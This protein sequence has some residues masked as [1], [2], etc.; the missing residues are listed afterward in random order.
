M[1]AMPTS[2]VHVLTP[3]RF[4]ELPC[5][6]TQALCREATTDHLIR[7]VERGRLRDTKFLRP[8]P[9]DVTAQEWTKNIATLYGAIPPPSIYIHPS[10]ESP[11][12]PPTYRRLRDITTAAWLSPSD[13]LTVVH[14]V[15]QER[16]KSG[17]GVPDQRSVHF[18][19]RE[20][21][22]RHVC[23]V[24]IPGFEDKIKEYGRSKFEALVSGCF[25]A[26]QLLQT[27]GLLE[28]THFPAVYPFVP[29]PQTI[30]P[31]QSKKAKPN[32]V[33]A[34]P[35]RT[36][37]FWSLSTK[38]LGDLWY[39][40]IV[41]IDGSEGEFG[42][43]AILTLHPLP[44]IPDFPLSF[45]GNPVNVQLRK[46][47]SR[48]FS[49]DELE[50]LRRATLRI[51]RFIGNKPLVCNLNQLPYLLFPLEPR[52]TLLGSLH[53]PSW[54]HEEYPRLGSPC[55]SGAVMSMA[56]SAFLP[57][58]TES[59]ENV[60]KDLADAVIQDRKIEYTKHYFV[61]KI[62][63]DLTPLHKPQE[64]EVRSP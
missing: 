58:T 10:T 38:T 37:L 13:A 11:V 35:R 56:S 53:G 47:Q 55:V 3:C 34:H 14:L 29:V 23:Q 64:G 40:T 16:F 4:D 41:I 1:Y 54:A 21:I 42:L 52:I 25:S 8:T 49:P 6:L 24:D 63:E 33:R 17:L 31:Q 46:C 50:Q 43:L 44:T 12:P 5:H 22:P 30:E 32:G 61:G 27:N 39:P 60:I 57:I 15:L 45:S 51:M 20:R 48:L 9:S 7:M 26:C 18:S 28:P 62:R 59:T 2:I 19:K 36:P